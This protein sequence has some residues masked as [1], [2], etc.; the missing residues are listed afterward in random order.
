L[1]AA[2]WQGALLLYT[3][4]ASGEYSPKKIAP[5]RL[6]SPKNADGFLVKI[7]NCLS[8]ILEFSG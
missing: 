3:P 6:I 4:I 7:H 2:R 5:A 8:A 1:S